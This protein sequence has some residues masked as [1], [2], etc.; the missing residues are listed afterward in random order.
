MF[1]S[2]H[3]KLKKPTIT[4]IYFRQVL[5]W[6]IFDWDLLL[7]H[8]FGHIN[9]GWFWYLH[10]QCIGGYYGHLSSKDCKGNWKTYST[11]DDSFLV[12]TPTTHNL[13]FWGKHK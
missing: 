8:N 13:S 6:V 3:S 11:V 9:N 1:R 12:P 7:G 2:T 10:M 4:V 5:L